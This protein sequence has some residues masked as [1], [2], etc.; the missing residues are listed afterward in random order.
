MEHH[1]SAGQ[2][3]ELHL[4]LVHKGPRVLEEL[5]RKAGRVAPLNTEAL[6]GVPSA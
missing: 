1:G 2:M 5:L 6:V 3:E 4:S